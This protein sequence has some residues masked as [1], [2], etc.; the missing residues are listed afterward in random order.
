MP[1]YVLK[2][3]V[4]TSE[5]CSFVTYCISGSYMD[6]IVRL[7]K[8]VHLV[9]RFEF[10]NVMFD[11]FMKFS[12]ILLSFVRALSVRRYSINYL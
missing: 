3:A 2:D 4:L 10:I 5:R 8:I 12:L 7:A 1:F 9:Y 11:V 6:N